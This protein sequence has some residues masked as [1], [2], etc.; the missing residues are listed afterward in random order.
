ML[1][2]GIPNWVLGNELKMINHCHLLRHIT[3]YHPTESDPTGG[4]HVI[5]QVTLESDIL[6]RDFNLLMFMG[7]YLFMLD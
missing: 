5:A 3:N 6:I 7:L 1:L 4:G 2:H